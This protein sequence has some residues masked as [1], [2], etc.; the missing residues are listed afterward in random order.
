MIHFVGVIDDVNN[1]IVR[2]AA[3]V[4][5]QVADLVDTNDAGCI[6]L[7]VSVGGLNNSSECWAG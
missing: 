3:S 5:A 4:L 2:D 6:N 7:S 1:L